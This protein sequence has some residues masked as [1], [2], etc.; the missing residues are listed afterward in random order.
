[1]EMELWQLSLFEPPLEVAIRES[2]FQLQVIEFTSVATLVTMQW[3]PPSTPATAPPKLSLTDDQRNIYLL[4]S[5]GGHGMD[6]HLKFEPMERSARLLE[7]WSVG[8]T[9]AQRKIAEVHLHLT[10]ENEHR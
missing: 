6:L 4:H 10:S 3:L 5:F 8:S 2:R 1:M 7:I 9:T